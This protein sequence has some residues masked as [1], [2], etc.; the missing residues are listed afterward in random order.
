MERSW[1]LGESQ[2]AGQRLP[3]QPM[4]RIAMYLEVIK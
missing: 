3:S 1:E 4:T 2:L